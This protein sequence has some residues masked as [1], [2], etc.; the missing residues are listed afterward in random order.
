M[1]SRDYI[2]LIKR[3]MIP[4][5]LFLSTRI[6][7]AVFNW[8]D[9]TQVPI[10]KMGLALIYGLR[11]DLATVLIINTF[12]I[13]FS[14]I[15]ISHSVFAGFKK[16]LYFFA[17][18]VFLFINV[19]DM[20]FFPFIGKKLTVDIF[21]M[22]SDIQDQSLQII[23]NYWYM[24]F[25]LLAYGII[26][27]RLYPVKKET[28]MYI[29]KLAWWK[30]TLIG[31]ITIVLTFIGIRGGVQMR[32]IS[33][34]QAYVFEEYVLGNMT[35]NPSY[36]LIRSLGKE[37]VT[38]KISY[39]PSDKVAIEL[40]N[41]Q[42]V[43]GKSG[44]K[45]PRQ[46]VVVLIIESLSQDY[47]EDGYTPFLREFAQKSFYSKYNFANGRRSLEALPSI[48]AGIPSLLGTPLYQTQYQTNEYYP[49]P[50]ILK[51]E[52]YATSFFHGGKK[53]TMD[54]DAYCESIG[55][56]KYFAK[57]DYP[58]PKHYDGHWGI[59]DHHYLKYFADMLDQEATP[60]F[61][62]LFT[63]SSHQPYSIPK[64]F[65]SII[66][67]GELEIHKSIRYVDMAL[68]EFFT[69]IQK[70]KW[71]DN[72]LFIITADHTQ[73]MRRQEFNTE[74]GRYRVPMFIFHPKINLSEFNTDRIT[75]H[76]DIMPTILDVLGMENP[77]SLY[78]GNS[79][80]LN[81]KGR[82]IN[83]ISNRFMYLA[84]PN[85]VT[86]IDEKAQFFQAN[87]ETNALELVEGNDV[88]GETLDELKAYI[89]YINNGLR[90]NNLYRIRA[91]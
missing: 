77:N 1:D 43:F 67:K 58:N 50:Q 7:F 63:L 30:V 54:F 59:F 40:I 91:D 86:L 61:T 22:S 45:I 29:P 55:V 2:V 65:A 47:V 56:D 60:F 23:L 38:R 82:M 90:N 78:F 52:G 15:P 53:G 13:I 6:F 42:R 81:E 41:K 4:I 84:P 83:F 21:E 73:K 25:F 66:P 87:L 44:V 79:V 27:W 35:L 62:G 26:L 32:S 28:I 34:K 85:F 16:L 76:V 51:S 72:T 64:D 9:Y 10:W 31:L 33:P 18:F 17:N 88:N 74:L 80:F 69:Y 37:P 36:T 11:F 3:L 49:L 70:K 68:K 24:G 39:F 89:Q 46:N 5:V 48:L 19:V 8:N 14:L 75:Q 20:K 71:Y 12:F 57:E